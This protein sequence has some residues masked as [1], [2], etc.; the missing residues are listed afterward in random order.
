VP[1]TTALPVGDDARGPEIEFG[2]ILD[3]GLQTA[4]EVLRVAELGFAVEHDV[5][6]G[7]CDLAQNALTSVDQSGQVLRLTC[8]EPGEI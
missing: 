5:G 8:Q 3:Q 4:I 6:E 7:V 1:V 2:E